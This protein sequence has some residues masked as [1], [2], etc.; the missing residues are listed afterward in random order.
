MCTL[1]VMS[2]KQCANLI[3]MLPCVMSA[4]CSACGGA[5]TNFKYPWPVEPPFVPEANP[6]GC[7]RRTFSTDPMHLPDDW[8]TSRRCPKF[9]TSTGQSDHTESTIVPRD[10]DTGTHINPPKQSH[11]FPKGS[12][13]CHRHFCSVVL[14]NSK[15]SLGTNLHTERSLFTLVSTF[16]FLKRCH[17]C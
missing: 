2:T 12:V 16:T 13:K 14:L 11:R 17:V 3:S 7:Y 8:Q 6:T 10:L 5:D 15:C 1:I 9:S 4:E